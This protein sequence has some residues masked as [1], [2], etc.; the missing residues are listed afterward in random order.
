MMFPYVYSGERYVVSNAGN[1]CVMGSGII[2]KIFVDCKDGV[3]EIYTT[4]E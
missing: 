1:M 2:T 4:A 3:P